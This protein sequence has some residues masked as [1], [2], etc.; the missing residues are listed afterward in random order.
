MPLPPAQL[1]EPQDC[2]PD[3]CCRL[4]K[5]IALAGGTG[6]PEAGGE[7]DEPVVEEPVPEPKELVPEPVDGLD[8][9]VDPALA[10]PV[11]VEEGLAL[12]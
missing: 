6:I 11:G 5:T 1:E 10:D 8:D 9:G 3:R 2:H 7:V 4:L 12:T